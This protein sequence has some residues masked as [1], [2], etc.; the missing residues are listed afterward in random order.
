M[1]LFT[2]LFSW[3]RAEEHRL[4]RKPPGAAPALTLD[5]SSS[6][7]PLAR[8]GDQLLAETVTGRVWKRAR[9]CGFDRESPFCRSDRLAGPPRLSALWPAGR[10]GVALGVYLR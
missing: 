10:P 8:R 6:A 7:V 9:C 2:V 3:R 4:L 5:S 1:L